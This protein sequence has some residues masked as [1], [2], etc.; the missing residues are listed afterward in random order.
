VQVEQRLEFLRLRGRKTRE[1]VFR[2]CAHVPGVIGG[3]D[4]AAIERVRLVF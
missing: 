2:V 1:R 3:I 4:A